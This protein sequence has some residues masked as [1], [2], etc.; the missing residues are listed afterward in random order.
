MKRLFWVT[1]G[2]VVCFIGMF[3]VGPVV[4]EGAD[5]KCPACPP[6][7]S[8]NQVDIDTLTNTSKIID[9]INEISTK[10]MKCIQRKYFLTQGIYTGA[11]ALTACQQ[12]PAPAS[13]YHMASIWEILDPSNLL[14]DTAHGLTLADSG[15][16]PPAGIN[17]WVRSGAVANRIYPQPP[18]W[19]GPPPNCD[20]WTT[21]CPVAPCGSGIVASLQILTLPTYVFQ[22]SFPYY[23]A[24]TWNIFHNFGCSSHLNVWCVSD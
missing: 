15:S 21:D 13:G 1:V 12:P 14:Y 5:A 16:G 18:G 10:G 20:A 24:P 8:P 3:S 6:P 22:D 11:E 23:L 17:G 4:A 19:Q 2:V 9:L 7:F